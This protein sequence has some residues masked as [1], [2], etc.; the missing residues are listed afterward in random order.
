MHLDGRTRLRLGT[1]TNGLYRWLA[2]LFPISM[3]GSVSGQS[4]LTPPSGFQGA[5]AVPAMGNVSGATAPGAQ[6]QTIDQLNAA[7]AAVP[8]NGGAN[9][10]PDEQANA[11]TEGKAPCSV[12]APLAAPLESMMQRGALHL[13]A[14]AA[15]QFLYATGIHSQPGQSSD[16]FTHTLSPGIGLELGPHV[17]LDY[18]ASIRFFSES[19]FHNTVDHSASLVA[20]VGY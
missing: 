11:K 5:P 4:Y 10:Q 9:A 18:A 1:A 17:R 15:N 13:H 20:S 8:A 6:P 14:K 3:V 7:L 16:T 19:D 12:T 2:V